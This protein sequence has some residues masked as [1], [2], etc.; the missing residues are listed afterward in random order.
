MR[1]LS[2]LV[3]LKSTYIRSAGW[4]DGRMAIRFKSGLVRFLRMPGHCLAG[5]DGSTISGKVFQGKDS[6]PTQEVGDARRGCVQSVPGR[7]QITAPL[8]RGRIPSSA[9]ID[10]SRDVTA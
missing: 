3:P 7:F 1:F 6:T 2:N 5:I 10:W 9:L 8:F 4:R